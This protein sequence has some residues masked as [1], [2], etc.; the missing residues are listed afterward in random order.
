MLRTAF[1]LE[2]GVTLTSVILLNVTGSPLFLITLAAG[3]VAMT[4][5]ARDVR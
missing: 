1:F 4:L 3:W 5:M 2:V